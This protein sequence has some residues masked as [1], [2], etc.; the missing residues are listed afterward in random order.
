MRVSRILGIDPGSRN[1]GFAIIDCDHQ[2]FKAI[3]HGVIQ[4]GNKPFADR[5]YN[6]FIDVQAIIQE[7]KPT[8]AAI[9]EVFVAK[10]ASS[11]LKLGHARGAAMV[12]MRSQGL[13]PAEYTALQIKKAVVGKGRADKSQ[14]Q[15][16]VRILLNIEQALQADAADALA[17]AL[18]HG[19][20]SQINKRY[21]GADLIQ[22]EGRFRKKRFQY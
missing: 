1:T 5:L 3:D 19:Q 18:C 8:V 12:A 20:V 2:S 14:V 4:V 22:P 21:F 7:F 17:I 10:N 6:I 16:M 11:A 9:E 15:L 13:E